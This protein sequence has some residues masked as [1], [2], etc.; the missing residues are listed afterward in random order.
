MADWRPPDM[1][2]GWLTA[3]AGVFSGGALALFWR[4]LGGQAVRLCSWIV[5]RHD[6]AVQGHTDAL[7]TCQQKI[8]ALE[9]RFS[10][11]QDR[12]TELIL[13]LN[14]EVMR[15]KTLLEE[16]EADVIELKRQQRRTG[17]PAEPPTSSSP[18]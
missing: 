12:T 3:A 17:R 11:Y 18:T 10:E 9:A 7:A 13:N 2:D 8:Q 4:P 5:A 14:V 15:L 1:T 16:R 6:R